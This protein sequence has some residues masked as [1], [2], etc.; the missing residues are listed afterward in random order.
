MPDPSHPAAN[1][2]SILLADIGST[3]T[4]VCLLDLIEGRYRFVAQ[5]EAP[6]QLAQPDGDLTHSV[7]RAVEQLELIA[8]RDLLRDRAPITPESA[9][10]QGVDL[11]LATSSAAPPLDCVLIGLTRDLS[12]ESARR[13][14]AGSHVIVRHTITLGTRSRRWDRQALA[15][16]REQPPDLLMLVGG[17]DTGPTAPL[18]NAAQVLAAIYQDLPEARRP[19]IVFAG[20]QEARRPVSALLA[21]QFD[22]RVVDNVRPAV[23]TETLGELQRELEALYA[24]I[25]L[26]ALPGYRR[27]DSWCGS[28]VIATTEALATVWRFMAEGGQ[29]AQGV[30]GI[31]VGG[32]TTYVGAAHSG[33]YQWTTAAAMGMSYGLDLLIATSGMR[34][35]ARWLPEPLPPQEL[36]TQLENARLRPLGLPTTNEDMALTQALLRQAILLTVRRMRRQHWHRLDVSELK[37]TTPPFDVLAAR[38]SALVNAPTDGLLA[39]TLLDAV[40]PTG[41]ARLV[42][43]WASLWPQLGALARVLPLAAAQVLEQDSLRELG[44]VIAP[45][46]EARDGERALHITLRPTVG[47]PME[48]MVPAGTIRRLP[49]GVGKQATIEVRPSRAFDIGLGQKGLGGRAVVTGG[50]LGLIIDTRGRPLSLPQDDTRRRTKMQEWLGKLTDDSPNA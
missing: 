46:G 33:L 13:A 49:L 32:A 4:H 44:T 18:E 36:A 2:H 17:V 10:G 15:A 5:A 1:P 39:L 40:Q 35:I 31:D 43:D 25:K 29:L 26:A 38:G 42:V 48:V 45:I 7:I 12:L 3:L 41:L 14:C 16:L 21:E 20:N 23:R 28:S 6:T 24:R 22:F 27:L 11:F 30:L 47:E 50:T 9:S 19:A 34:D 37:D 8:Q